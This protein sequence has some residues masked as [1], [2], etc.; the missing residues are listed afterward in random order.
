MQ[1]FPAHTPS[2]FC[3]LV[4]AEFVAVAA[5]KLLLLVAISGVG[6]RCTAAAA[7]PPANRRRVAGLLSPPPVDKNPLVRHGRL[8]SRLCFE[9]ADGPRVALHNAEQALVP[10]PPRLLQRPMAWPRG[11]CARS[12]CWCCCSCAA[13]AFSPTC[14]A[15]K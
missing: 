12:C 3:G 5:G 15:C 8:L 14:T 4:G 10:N 9:H 2:I 7:A 1:G 6:A 11:V 13:A